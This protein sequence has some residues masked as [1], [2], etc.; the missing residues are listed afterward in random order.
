MRKILKRFYRTT[1][2]FVLAIVG[3]VVGVFTTTITARADTESV[4]A[5]ENTN[6]MDDLTGATIDGE[7]FSLTK[8]AFDESKYTDVLF[9]AEYCYSF[10]SDKQDNY[11]LYLYIWN[12]QGLTFEDTSP[13][14]QVQFSY[15][16]EADYYKYPLQFL[17][18]STQSGYEGL[19]YKFKIV[20]PD[21]VKAE[22]LT[23]LNS[24]ERVY[25]ISGVELLT[26]GQA[27]AKE[28]G[29][30]A[31]FTYKG[32]S[33]EY[34]PS[35]AGQ[36][37]LS[38][39][40]QQGEVITIRDNDLHFTYYRPEGAKAGEYFTQDTLVSVYFSIP[41]QVVEKYG[42]LSEIR[43]QWQEAMLAPYLVTGNQTIYNAIQ[44]YLGAEVGAFDYDDSGFRYGLIGGYAS[45][46]YSGA[47]ISTTIRTGKVGYN[48]WDNY[49]DECDRTLS[50]LCMAFYAGSGTD[51]AD[52]YIVRGE[53]ILEKMRSYGGGVGSKLLG[54]Y[55][56]ELF[57]E[58]GDY[59]VVDIPS[60][61]NYSLTSEKISQTWWEKIFGL[62]HTEFSEVY[63][64]IEAIKVVS[65]TDFKST[66]EQTCQ[67]LFIDEG[68]YNEFESFYNSKKATETV[69]LFRFAV[70]DYNAW[71]VTEGKWEKGTTIQ[72]FMPMTTYKF[73]DTDTNAYFAEETVYLGFDILQMTFDNG[74]KRSVIPVVSSPIDIV[75]DGT[76][77]VY[78]TSDKIDWWLI[79][80]LVLLAVVLLVILS[81]ILSPIIKFL[82]WLICLPF[83][84][85]GKLFKKMERRRKDK[86]NDTG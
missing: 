39:T 86:K 33:A 44:D 60:D 3:L 54:V 53:D 41:T 61:K 68:D 80:I 77:P 46:T 66:T 57:S 7:P 11:N 31:V 34:G 25:H 45:K 21:E 6:V 29:V 73:S 56:L 38:Y 67:H 58:V 17:N 85:L 35:N 62:S 59:T 42:Y 79:L 63:D 52:S 22:M 81:P 19:F 18:K 78:T 24:S 74:E 72:N 23:K 75:P 83:K 5:Y 50:K 12:P 16:F 10:Y 82:V 69:Y 76:P 47:S 14:N 8:Y 64:G 49:I 70:G 9:L 1:I 28:Y 26:K 32:Y 43:A 37:T 71:E 20:L 48:V 13:Q 36:S 15:G 30:N 65:D 84:A 55:P 51:S 4:V 27:T 2:S 40:K